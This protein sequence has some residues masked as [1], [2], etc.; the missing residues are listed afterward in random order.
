MDSRIKKPRYTQFEEYANIATHATGAALSIFALWMMVAF[1]VKNGDSYHI[2]S[3]SIFGATMIL[4]YLMST[5]YHSVQHPKLK[6][7]FRVL[8]H[9]SIYLLIAGSYTPFTLITM[10]NGVGWT[11]FAA[12]WILAISGVVFKLFFTGRF[13]KIS[14]LIYVGMGWLAI[15]AI[16]P[17]ID[18]VSTGALIW[19]VAG[20]LLYTIGVLFYL[21]R[22][23]PYHHAIWH[24]FVMAGSMSHFAA[25]YWYVLPISAV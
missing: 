15:L 24:L 21:W 5:L 11:L 20:G 1:A 7:I 17:I 23:V 6:Y 25:V 12:I 22:R 19:L 3:V 4:L 8:D 2:T 18:S 16:K 14:T 13:D 10:R 9:S